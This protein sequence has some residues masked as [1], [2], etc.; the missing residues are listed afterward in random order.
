[1]KRQ[2]KAGGIPMLSRDIIESHHSRYASVNAC[3]IHPSAVW[4]DGA[5]QKPSGKFRKLTSRKQVMFFVITFSIAPL[6]QRQR[7]SQSTRGPS[8]LS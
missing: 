6:L 5:L 3:D 4:D 7:A 2:R 8:A 1:M